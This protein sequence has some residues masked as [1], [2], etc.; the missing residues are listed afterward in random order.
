MSFPR[1]PKYKD[2]GVAAKVAGIL[3]MPSANADAQKCDVKQESQADGTRSVPATVAGI[4]Q[5]P[6]A[7][8]ASQAFTA[9]N[10]LPFE[11]LWRTDIHV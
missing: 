7:M 2:R 9:T 8:R 3:R 4:V 10:Q 6:S 1:D 11:P 5:M